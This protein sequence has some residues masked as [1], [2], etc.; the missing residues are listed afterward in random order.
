MAIA[1]A[2]IDIDVKLPD[3]KI[4][5]EY[6]EKYKVVGSTWDIGPVLSRMQDNEWRDMPTALSA[7]YNRYNTGNDTYR[8]ANGIDELMPEIPYM[9]NQLPFKK[10]T[11]VVL[12]K[13]T[14]Q[15]NH[16]YDPH[17]SD[18]Y[19][20]HSEIEIELEPRRYNIL[21]TKHNTSSFFVSDNTDKKI[22]PVLTKERPAFAFCERYHYHGADYIGPDKVM[23]SVFGILDR[24]KH[25]EMISNSVRKYPNEVI[26]FTDPDNPFDPKHQFKEKY[27][28]Y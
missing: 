22:H 26:R 19:E 17:T 11:V 3:E 27:P 24:E 28:P 1:F 14:A 9:L 4:L 15:V 21:L 6:I 5:L 12:F 10:L 7:L 23:L 2:P 16:H 13:Q 20:D 25:K 8:Y 18:V